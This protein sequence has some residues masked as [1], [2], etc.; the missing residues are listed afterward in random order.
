MLS[1]VT[2]AKGG[3]LAAACPMPPASA[4]AVA[5]SPLTNVLREHLDCSFSDMWGI[6]RQGIEGGDIDSCKLLRSQRMHLASCFPKSLRL[7]WLYLAPFGFSFAG[8]IAWEKTF[9]TWSRGP[10][11]IGFSLAHLHPGFFLAGILCCWG[12]ML[13]SIT[14]TIYLIRKRKEISKLD[15]LIYVLA[16]LVIV[17]FVV[18]DDAFAGLHK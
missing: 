7:T 11:M 4:P 9:L 2:S 8:R 16:L 10:Q 13:W 18:P 3:A 12:F 6:I 15:W 1:E 14:A 17:A 5:V